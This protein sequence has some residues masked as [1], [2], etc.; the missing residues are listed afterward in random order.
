MKHDIRQTAAERGYGSRWQ[1]ARVT[2]LRNNP[3]CAECYKIDRLTAAT[4][5]YHI[6]PHQGNQELFWDHGNWQPLCESCHN[7]KTA[8]EDGAFG[9]K[10]KTKASSA[11]GADGLPVDNMHHWNHPG[12]G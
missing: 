8:R 6:K 4:V 3:L 11:C 9:N 7:R 2:Y 12:G 5:V 1:K 10:G